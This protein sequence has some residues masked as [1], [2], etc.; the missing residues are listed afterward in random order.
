MVA[1]VSRVAPAFK[2]RGANS[3]ARRVRSQAPRRCVVKAMAEEKAEEETAIAK[4]CP[5]GSGC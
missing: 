1:V 3:T 2:A 4:V 5:L